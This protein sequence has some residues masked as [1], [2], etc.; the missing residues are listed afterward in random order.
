MNRIFFI[1]KKCSFDELVKKSFC[2]FSVSTT[3]SMESAILKIPSFTFSNCFFNEMKFCKNISLEDIRKCKNLES[4]VK[5]LIKENKNKSFLKN[6]K[7][8]RNSF[9]GS[10]YGEKMNSEKNLK[11]FA[12]AIN[13]VFN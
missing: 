8:L 6:L 3:A 12:S 2:T 10:L 4:L 1:E 7:F 13:E 9:E 5:S 11:N